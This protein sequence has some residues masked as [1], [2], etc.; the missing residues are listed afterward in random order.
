MPAKHGRAMVRHYGLKAYKP[1]RIAYL[2]NGW[3]KMVS[4]IVWAAIIGVIG[5]L[6]G[7][8]IGTFLEPVRAFFAQKKHQEQLRRTLYGELIIKLHRALGLY[9]AYKKACDTSN[10]TYLKS[11]NKLGIYGPI[12][13]HEED[14]TQ[15]D[16]YQL[17]AQEFQPLAN[18]YFRLRTVVN[19]LNQFGNRS[20]E[21]DYAKTK[22]NVIEGEIRRAFHAISS[23]FKDN[24]HILEEIDN[25]IL[26]NDWHDLCRELIE[27]PEYKEL[28]VRDYLGDCV[29]AAEKPAEKVVEEAY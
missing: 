29:E 25:G 19:F 24:V 27:R 7:T 8:L 18:A 5:A 17:T 6:A 15:A 22:L 13:F 14:T 4:D 9:E 2:W 1:L 28:K 26:L 3:C 23:A 16:Y 21:I 11:R 10:L 12:A 20:L